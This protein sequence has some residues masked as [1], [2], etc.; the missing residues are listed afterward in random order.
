MAFNDCQKRSLHHAR[1]R[2][3]DNNLVSFDELVHHAEPVDQFCTSIVPGLISNNRHSP[4]FLMQQ[5]SECLYSKAF[6]GPTNGLRD[7][8]KYLNL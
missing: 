5:L 2:N 6:K 1:K 8:K 7:V 4:E 3:K